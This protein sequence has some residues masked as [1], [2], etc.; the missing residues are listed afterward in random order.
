[1]SYI[2]GFD[3]KQATLFPQ[4]I[5]QIIDKENPVRFI[6]LF[7]DTIKVEEY[8]FKDI[9]LNTNGR[10]PF[11]PADL[12]KLYI[13]GYMNKIRSSRGLE[14]ECKRNIELIWLLKGLIP[15]HNTIS[16]FRKDNPKAIKKVFRQT[17]QLAK[18]PRF[19]WRYTNSW[20]WN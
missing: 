5:D 13:Y 19:N 7:V 18:K 6:D 10:P 20:R 8:G 16:N 11:H 17:V 15:D 14:K 4:S 1:M 12:L 3:R 9:T 2:T